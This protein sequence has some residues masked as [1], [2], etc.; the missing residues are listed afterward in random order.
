MMSFREEL[1]QVEQVHQADWEMSELQHDKIE[2]LFDVFERIDGRFCQLE[3]AQDDLIGQIERLRKAAARKQQQLKMQPSQEPA[4]VDDCVVHLSQSLLILQTVPIDQVLYL[5][6]DRNRL[7]QD[8]TVVVDQVLQEIQ[9]HLDQNNQQDRQKLTQAKALVHERWSRVKEILTKPYTKTQVVEKKPPLSDANQLTRSI[10]QP[11]TVRQKHDIMANIYNKPKKGGV[12]HPSLNQ[13]ELSFDILHSNLYEIQKDIEEVTENLERLMMSKKKMYE[14]CLSLEKE[15]NDANKTRSEDQI[16]S[17]LHQVMIFTQQLFDKQHALD[18]EREQLLKEYADIEQQLDATRESLQQVRPPALLQGLLDRLDTDETPRVRVEKDWKEDS[19][20]VTEIVMENHQAE[21]DLSCA[22]STTSTSQQEQEMQLTALQAKQLNVQCASKLSTLCYIARL[23]ASLYCLKVLASHSIGKSRQNLLQVQASLGQASTDLDETR[24]QMTQLYDDAAEVARQVFSLKTELETIVRHRKEEVV[25]VWEVVDEVSEGVDAKSTQC[26]QQTHQQQQP[27][28]HHHHQQPQK[29][30]RVPLQVVAD[31]GQQQ[32]QQERIEEQ[33]RHQWIVRELEQLQHVHESLQDAIDELKQEQ[34]MIGQS[35]RQ[36]ATVF[37]EP[38]VDRLV[39]QDEESL[40][41]VSDRLAELMDRVRD[42]DIGLRPA[43]F[44][45]LSTSESDVASLPAKSTT[46]DVGPRIDNANEQAAAT[47]TPIANS[48]PNNNRL[49]RLSAATN[50]LSI[51]T[52]NSNRSSFL[53]RSPS[54][55]VLDGNNN[56]R[57]STAISIRTDKKRMSMISATSLS[58][59]SSYQQ[60][61]MLARASKLS[62][63]LSDVH[64]QRNSG[65]NQQTYS[66]K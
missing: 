60:E 40:L 35:L 42:N 43:S 54:S 19:N 7:Y 53:V 3:M 12:H 41:C 31:Q 4:D 38:Q 30:K 9:A 64:Q 17:E 14:M 2:K 20:L 47:T 16:Q 34:A 58:S 59:L 22:S 44:S 18:K 51:S 61:R 45:C 56:K 24:N 63:A 50:R 1:E 49:S 65:S 13:L 5:R 46:T 33:D 48:T 6:D 28:A 39:G 52:Y 27:Q 36:L 23:D 55:V 25:K 10:S 21:D 62:N 37:I 8:M 15:L 57:L 66:R 11:T 29:E 32:Q 26:Q